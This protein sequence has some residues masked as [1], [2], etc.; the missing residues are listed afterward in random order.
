MLVSHLW[1]LSLSAE[2]TNGIM[3]SRGTLGFVKSSVVYLSSNGITRSAIICPSDA[4]THKCS[5]LLGML[6]GSPA[7][8][9]G[10]KGA[11]HM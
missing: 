4:S 5:Y 6:K 10:S 8:L 9:D 3:M 7:N 1:M 11:T 2:T